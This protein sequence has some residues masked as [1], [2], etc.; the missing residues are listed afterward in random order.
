[1]ISLT[2]NQVKQLERANAGHSETLVEQPID[3]AQ[4]TPGRAKILRA[5]RSQRFLV[6]LW[7]EPNGAERLT[8][9]R[10]SVRTDGHWIDGVTWDELMALKRQAGYGNSHAIECYPADDEV[11][12]VANMRHLWLVDRP[13]VT[14]GKA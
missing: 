8:C 6:V 10:T 2:R 7:R 1:M 12:N 3:A 4:S 13:W 5:W 9:S 14:W 11:V